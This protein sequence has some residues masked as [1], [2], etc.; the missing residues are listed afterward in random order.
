MVLGAIRAS[1][2]RN[3]DEGAAAI[4]SGTE[5]RRLTD[6]VKFR[7]LPDE[8]KRLAESVRE[9]GFTSAGDYLRMLAF[10]DGAMPRRPQGLEIPLTAEERALVRERAKVNGFERVDDYARARLLDRDPE[11]FT[12]SRCIMELRRLTG[13]QKHL[14]NHDQLRSRDYAEL[15]LKIGDAIEAVVRAAERKGAGKSV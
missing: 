15:L 5:R 12:V 2:T 4:A 10:G 13:L 8:K 3:D 7:V 14:F 6:F 11:A 1:L 9:H